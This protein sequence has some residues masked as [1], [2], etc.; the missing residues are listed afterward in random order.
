MSEILYQLDGTT[1]ALRPSV[2]AITEDGESFFC[3]A[4]EWPNTTPGLLAAK[5]EAIAHLSRRVAELE[6]RIRSAAEPE[7][8]LTVDPVA[9]VQPGDMLTCTRCGVL[10]AESE[11]PHFRGKRNGRI[12]TSCKRT[13]NAARVARRSDEHAA[14]DEPPSPT[15]ETAPAQEAAPE[16]KPSKPVHLVLPDD[17]EWRCVDCDPINAGAFARSMSDSERCVKHASRANGKQVVW[18]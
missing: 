17:P 4:D 5:D 15:E 9:A 6:D 16:P 7:P 14:P 11:F 2:Y 12:C 18:S 1:Y 3:Y 8:V 10:K 13:E